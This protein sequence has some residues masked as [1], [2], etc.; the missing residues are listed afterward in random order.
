MPL[1]IS[2]S[3]DPGSRSRILARTACEELQRAGSA[4]QFLDLQQT[5]LPLCDGDACY[6]EPRVQMV[7]AQVR[8]ARGVILA[9]PVY[10]Y[11]V[12]AA[13]KNLVELTGNAW[14]GHVVAF[15]LA[16]GGKGSYMSVLGLANSLMLDFRCFIVPRFVYATKQ[17]FD[18]DSLIDPEVRGRIREL[19]DTLVRIEAAVRAARTQ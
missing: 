10:N 5:P 3:L 16:A 12:S 9:A 15:L 6:A 1:V 18:G 8:A 4:M 14:E 2:C 17:A 19:T 7:S 11:D 13:A